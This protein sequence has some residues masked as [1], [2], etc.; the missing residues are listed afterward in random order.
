MTTSIDTIEYLN[1]RNQTV[2]IELSKDKKQYIVAV[3][4]YG[5]TNFR[6]FASEQ[7]AND[8][9]IKLQRGYYEQ[10]P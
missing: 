8:Y 1:T 10:Q 3:S 4:V 6:S 9:I 2:K 5:T 7:Q